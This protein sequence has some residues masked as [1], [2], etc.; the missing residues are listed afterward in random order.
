M[1]PTPRTEITRLAKRGYHDTETIYPILDEGLVCH[2]SCHLNG[3]PSHQPA[4][5]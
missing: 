5:R 2:V 4:L 1:N 3:Q